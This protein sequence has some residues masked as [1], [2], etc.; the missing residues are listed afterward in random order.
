[1]D[2]ILID[3]SKAFDTVPHE[4]LLAKV[5]GLGVKGKL[6]DWV[7]SFLGDRSHRVVL[8]GDHSDWFEAS[9]GVPQGSVAGPTLFSVYTN[10]LPEQLLSALCNMFA[11]D[12]GTRPSNPKP[13][14]RLYKKI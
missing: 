10:D 7:S 11:D 5:H 1:M 8:N 2:L 9:S 14:A 4:R 12:L 3:F 13:I 6:L